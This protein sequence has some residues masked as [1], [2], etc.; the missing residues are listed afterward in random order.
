[1]SATPV[2]DPRRNPRAAHIARLAGLAGL[3]DNRDAEVAAI[4]SP[5]YLAY[6][7]GRGPRPNTRP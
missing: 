3:A 4:L 1:M 5:A 6:V 2:I 7:L